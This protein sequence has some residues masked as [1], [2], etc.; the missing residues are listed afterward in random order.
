MSRGGKREGAGRPVKPDKKKPFCFKLSEI[1]EKAVRK[2][3]KELREKTEPE[4]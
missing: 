1:E 4:K 3:L 2:L